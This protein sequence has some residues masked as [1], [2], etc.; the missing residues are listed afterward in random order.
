MYMTTADATTD[1]MVD[2]WMTAN[3]WTAQR[4]YKTHQRQEGLTV[5][6]KKKLL[7]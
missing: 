6:F 1:S 7:I 3:R 5:S 2:R 4:R